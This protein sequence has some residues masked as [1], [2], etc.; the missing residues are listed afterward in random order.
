MGQQKIL[1]IC[2]TIFFVVIGTILLYIIYT[3][4]S[5][6]TKD[7]QDDQDD[8]DD[9]DAQDD[10]DD[11]DA[12][13][14]KDDKDDKSY[15]CYNKDKNDCEI[16]PQCTQYTVGSTVTKDECDKMYKLYCYDKQQNVCKATVGCKDGIAEN[17]CNSTYQQYYCYNGI[18]CV[19]NDKC[20]PPTGNL[21]QKDCINKNQPY[22]CYNKYDNECGDCNNV[23]AIK[24]TKTSNI[25]KC[26]LDNQL[27]YCY[28]K[29]KDECL[30]N[31]AENKCDA[32]N[33]EII[34]QSACY[35]KNRIY[36]CLDTDNNTCYTDDKCTKETGKSKKDCTASLKEY[37]IDANAC[38]T[39]NCSGDKSQG[40]ISKDECLKKLT[41][42]CYDAKTKKCVTNS[43]CTKDTTGSYLSES[44]C[45]D[46]NI[47]YYCYKDRI[48]KCIPCNKITPNSVESEKGCN[49]KYKIKTK[50]C[51]D[52]KT[53]YCN[54]GE[55]CT[56]YPVK[57]IGDSH[58]PCIENAFN[59]KITGN[60]NTI[61]DVSFLLDNYNN[62]V[63]TIELT[64]RKT[65]YINVFVTEEYED[66]ELHKENITLKKSAKPYLFTIK[67]NKLYITGSDIKKEIP[68]NS[69]SEIFITFST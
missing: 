25:N 35:E 43:T 34:P 56:S 41:Y 54:E 38:Y 30:P 50:Y 32:S 65:R 42:Y 44:D 19:T 6:N 15:Y 13:D 18:T 45:M 49:D 11:K 60:F 14:D 7:D 21:S 28:N 66:G 63:T 37:C 16:T 31:E 52:T 39:D 59:V 64:Q 46:E 53:K 1:I 4:T 69:S 5:K 12:Q 20:K 10:K 67:L 61:S 58:L 17:E 22:F 47:P 40:K 57:Y 29:E 48:K 27:Y 26:N 9:K 23:N 62:S 51:Y 24:T 2:F 33:G 55:E 3:R 36:Y 68:I 8:K